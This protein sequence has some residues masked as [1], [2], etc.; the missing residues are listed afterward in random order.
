MTIFAVIGLTSRSADAAFATFTETVTGSGNF[1]GVNFTNALITISGT[2]DTDKIF[3]PSG[4]PG[5]LALSLAS[6]TVTVS[7]F[8]PTSFTQNNVQVAVN[9]VVHTAG[10]FYDSSGLIGVPIFSTDNPAF[11]NYS[12]ATSIGPL[13]GTARLNPGIAFQTTS[14][15]LTINSASTLATFQ[16]VVSPNAVPEPSSLVLCGV[17]AVAGLGG[18]A[19]RRFA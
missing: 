5:V 4:F 16:A 15:N 6:N 11:A 19:R 14:G 10:F 18:W 12:L 17:V 13:S 3:A 2:G 9:Q 7:G 1:G 8:A